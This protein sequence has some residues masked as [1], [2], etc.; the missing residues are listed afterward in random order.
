MLSVL[1]FVCC[2]GRYLLVGFHRKFSVNLCACLRN[3]E[4]EAYSTSVGKLY[5]SLILYTSNDQSYLE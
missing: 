4:D 1:L 3:D 2:F 5:D